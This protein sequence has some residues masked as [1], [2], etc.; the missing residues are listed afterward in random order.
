[1]NDA[2]ASGSLPRQLKALGP[3]SNLMGITALKALLL[4]SNLAPTPYEI[5]TR[6]SK[7]QSFQL[8]NSADFK[9]LVTGEAPNQTLISA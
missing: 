9:L 5:T 8:P 3:E 6:S 4:Q 1:M 7:T 2:A